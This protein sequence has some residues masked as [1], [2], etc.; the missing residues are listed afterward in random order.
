[1]LEIVLTHEESQRL[2]YEGRIDFDEGEM[3]P[4]NLPF[5]PLLDSNGNKFGEANV[6]LSDFQYIGSGRISARYKIISL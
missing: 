5:L 3:I 2:G 6:E 1:M 4:T